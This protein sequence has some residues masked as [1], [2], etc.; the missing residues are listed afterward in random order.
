MSS[1]PFGTSLLILKISIM[2]DRQRVD[3]TVHNM[4]DMYEAC[5]RNGFVM[6]K[7]KSKLCKW[8]FLRGVFRKE[9]Y[10]P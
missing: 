2:V 10:V 4:K 5:I 3:D 7:F 1:G 9:I 6:P 8:D